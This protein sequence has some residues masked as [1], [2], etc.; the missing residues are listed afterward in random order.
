MKFIFLIL[1]IFASQMSIS[2][3]IKVRIKKSEA[4]LEIAGQGLRISR[5]E[6]GFQPA[7]LIP[8]Q[9]MRIQLK[10]VIKRWPTWI[11][12]DSRAKS[13]QELVGE[14]IFVTGDNLT[15]GSK[16][17]PHN[18]ILNRNS[19]GQIEVIAELDLEKYL[20]GVLPSEMPASWPR[21]ALKAQAVASR[22]YAL[23]ILR[24]RKDLPFQV[25]SSIM[26]QVFEIQNHVG[27]TDTVRE[28]IAEIVRATR[29]LVLVDSQN[30]P[31]RAHYHADCGGH[32][33]TAASVWGDQIQE[34]GVTED[35][36]CPLSPLA[37]WK[38]RISK[39]E[40]SELLGEFLGVGPGISL[41][42]MAILGRTPSGRVSDLNIVLTDKSQHK[43]RSHELR[44]IIG[45]NA[46]K[47][48]NFNIFND[49]K[50][51]VFEGKGHG[52]GVGMCQYGARQLAAKGLSFQSI[53]KNYYSSARLSQMSQ[54]Q[55]QAL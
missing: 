32:T 35:P 41:K 11:I 27:A 46:L 47:S 39:A 23:A 49:G 4:S 34:T 25:E 54:A 50:D 28:K 43:L 6:T 1:T 33:E 29:G 16:P 3:T 9:Q 13:K 18:L 8:S 52:H 31:V 53:L 14:K 10:N 40:I 42:S 37:R 51:Y 26:D 7:A 44:R 15:M 17:V 2:E 55:S 45:F 24:E 36:Q 30:R 5:S 21:E 48:T 20:T 12:T 38:L 22:S 19:F